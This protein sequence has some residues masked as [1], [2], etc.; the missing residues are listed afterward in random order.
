[1]MTATSRSST[2]LLVLL[3]ACGPGQPGDTQGSSDTTSE[4]QT[5]ANTDDPTTATPTTTDTPSTTPPTTSDPT[6]DVTSDATTTPGETGTLTS[7]DTTE[8]IPEPLFCPPG[9]TPQRRLNRAQYL[10]TLQD[11]FPGVT[12]P[13]VELPFDPRV[14][15]FDNIADAQDPTP[16]PL[17]DDAAAQVAAAVV[18]AG[19]KALPCPSDGGA[20]PTA[21]GHEFLTALAPRSLRRPLDPADL[22]KRLD[23]FDAGLADDGFAAALTNAIADL[24][25]DDAF[26]HLLEPGGTDVPDNPGVL[27]L[28]GFALASRMSYFLWNS[29]PDAELFAAAMNGELD[30]LPGIDAQTTRMLADPRARPAISRLAEQW[31]FMHHL[32]DDDS[33]IP[34]PVRASM[35]EEIVRLVQ[36][37]LFDGPQTLSGLLSTTT[38]FPDK[39][40]A[41]IYEVAAPAEPFTAVELD[42]ERR[43]GLLTRAAWLSIGSRNDTHSPFIRGWRLNDSLFCVQ[44]P[45]PPPDTPIEPVDLPPD[46][47]TREKYDT[48]LAEPACAG[49]H[50]PAHRVGY[51][52][53]HYAALGKWQDTEN[54]K[55]VDAS[56]ELIL[57]SDIEGPFASTAELA[58]KLGSSRTVHDCT[59]RKHYMYGL[60]RTLTDADTCG[61]EQLQSEF[62]A[63]SGNI[64]ELLRSI[65]RSDGFRHR[66]AR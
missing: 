46:A 28:D 9:P 54:G 8:Q 62:F 34:P 47:T 66:L 53:E 40:L 55:P 22:Q 30:D 48:I 42:P 38:A 35:R 37:V 24:L 13:E 19:A 43:T 11:L 52:F 58:T 31:L 61:L 4:P 64:H 60:G 3:A 41:G 6:S 65:V 45:P 36:N 29:M 23:A 51:G 32:T 2:A 59:T 21:C 20:D 39:T 10:T 27:K 50:T 1:M 57:L 25:T 26:L 17:Y 14:E 12:L 63:N 5:S 15:G 16:S 56:A 44:L 33:D 18:A 7:D 49:C